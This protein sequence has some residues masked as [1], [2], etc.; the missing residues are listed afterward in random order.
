MEVQ[1]KISDVG[2]MV[3]KWEDNQK[4]N[5]RNTTYYAKEFS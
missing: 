5:K 1:E 4:I 2:M 3:L